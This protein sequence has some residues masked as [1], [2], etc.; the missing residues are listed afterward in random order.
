MLMVEEK[1]PLREA[2]RVRSL[3]QEKKCLAQIDQANKMVCAQGESIEKQG[4]SPDAGNII[5]VDYSVVS[6]VIGLVGVIHQ[7]RNNVRARIATVAGMLSSS[8][9]KGQW[10]I[11]LDKY[12]VEFCT[13]KQ[14][15]LPPKLE[16]IC[17]AILTGEYN[18]NNTAVATIKGVHQAITEFVSPCRRLKGDCAGGNCKVGP[19]G[20]IKKG[21]KCT[22]MCPYNGKC[23][24]NTHNGK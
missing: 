22:S 13:D 24:T 5:K 17:Q 4:A 7:M 2:V 18:N 6:Y 8:P 19:C 14:A 21:F 1:T 12:I 3:S 16:R 23:S 20:C 11:L 10:W 9:R 15:N